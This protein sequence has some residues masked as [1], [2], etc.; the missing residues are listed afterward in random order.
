MLS[1][2]CFFFSVNLISGHRWDKS[3]NSASEWLHASWIIWMILLICHE[4]MWVIMWSFSLTSVFCLL[5]CILFQ[6]GRFVCLVFYH[7]YRTNLFLWHVQLVFC[8]DRSG[9][10]KLWFVLLK[11]LVKVCTVH[12]RLVCVKIAAK[13]L[14]RPFL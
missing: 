4:I 13:A 8:R 11:Q 14:S 12:E 1:C 7:L 2:Q 5:E 6:W 10:S 9:L 3:V